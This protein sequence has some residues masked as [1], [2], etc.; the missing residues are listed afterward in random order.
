MLLASWCRQS[1]FAWKIDERFDKT[2]LF[3]DW[4]KEENVRLG[5]ELLD[6]LS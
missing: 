4:G 6:M 3:N 2:T 1:R 5:K